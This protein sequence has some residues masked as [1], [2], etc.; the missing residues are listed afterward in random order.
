MNELLENLK[1]FAREVWLFLSSVLFLKNFAMMAG[2]TLGILLLTNWWLGCYTHHGESVQVDDFTGM[3]LSDA[4][5]QGRDKDFRFE[6]MDSVWIEGKPSGMIILQNP[7]PLSRV[8]EGRKIYVTVTGNAESESLPKFSD[9]SYDYDR[10]A[11]KLAKR[12]IKS[13]VKERAFDAKQAENTILYFYHHGK[14]VTEQMVKAGYEVMPGDVL[15]FVVSERLSNEM[16]IPDL[17]CMNFTAAE[18]LVSTSNLNI[19][20]VYDDG[21]VTD[22]ST[23][24]ISRQEP[25]YDPE[26]T[27]QMGGQI[28]VWLTQNLP[29]GCSAFDNSTD[30][31]SDF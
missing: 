18:F 23:A 28:N 25:A 10:Y 9:S 8:K 29:E 3:H 26:R 12:G 7:K 16:E 17:V 30:D 11:S 1:A 2:V 6:V 19:G 14:K 15:E 4:K 27:I 21:T 22:R 24:F 5:K 31:D 20:Q 13:R